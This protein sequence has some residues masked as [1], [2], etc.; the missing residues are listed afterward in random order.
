MGRGKGKKK[1]GGHHGGHRGGRQRQRF[2]N[3]DHEFD[4]SLLCRPV[5]SDDPP[6][7]T[8]PNPL[9]GLSLRMWDFAQCDPKVNEIL[10]VCMPRLRRQLNKN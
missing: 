9:K 3:A 10:Y 6:P 8:R 4:A 2:D 7:E 1:G 5:G